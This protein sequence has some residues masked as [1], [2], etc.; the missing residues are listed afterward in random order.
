MVI[1][2]RPLNIHNWPG[3][4]DDLDNDEWVEDEDGEVGNELG[5]DEFAP[6]EVDG[7]I[8]RVLPQLR[9]H[10]GRVVR[11][12]VD[13]SRDLKELGDVEGDREKDRSRNQPFDEEVN[14][15]KWKI[16]IK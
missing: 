16:W 11:L 10:D 14:I 6:D 2:G 5:Q 1:Y 15:L 4:L 3:G 13:H 7:H 12:R 9:A 8:E